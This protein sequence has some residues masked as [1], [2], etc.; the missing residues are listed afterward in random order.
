MAAAG[1]APGAEE[2]NATG[3]AYRVLVIEDDRSQAVFAESILHGAGMETRWVALAADAM[4]ALQDFRPDLVLMDLHLPDASGA[5]L[6][7]RIRAEDA[8]AHLPIVFLTGDPDPETE[9]VAL[10]SGADDF[11]SK[12]IRP[13]HLIS[14]VQG[15]VRRARAVRS[16]QQGTLG[17]DRDP[18]TGL[19]RRDWLLS[20]L[21]GSAAA[22]LVEVQHLDALR[23]RLGFAGIEAL[24]RSAGTLLAGIQPQAARLNDNSFLVLVDAA[25]AAGRADAARAVRDGLGQPIEHAGMP[26]RLRVAVAHAA[27]ADV[28]S[29]PLGAL[30]RTLRRARDDA[31]HLA[32][33]E[34]EAASAADPSRAAAIRAALDD[35]R[36]ELA[37][38]PIAAV[39][40]GGGAQFQTLLR[41]RDEHGLLRTASELI[42]EAEAA[43]L[44]DEVDQWVFDRALS[45]IAARPAGAAERRL[46]VSQS[47]QTI[48]SDPKAARAREALARHGVAPGS[49][50]IDLRMD[51][52]LVH[53]LAMTDFCEQLVPHG[54]AFCLGQYIH[55]D[56]AAG[57]LRQLPLSYLR[58]SPRYSAPDTEAALRGE[59]REIIGIAHGAGIKVIGAQVETP[60]AA[61]SLWMSGVDFIQGN[62]IQGP[63]SSL[64]F[65]FHH[66]VL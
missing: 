54:V 19:Y 10:D 37:F 40:G 32:G 24:L 12:P 4:D 62:L 27:L 31:S 3:E 11:L 47:P 1:Q 46:F 8:Y 36:L 18:K 42:Q 64:D 30:E 13:R 43:G 35:G 21:S 9:F 66:S 5:D 16:A 49:L 55:G 51:D 6:T 56:A 20:R 50:V 7:A 45:V 48:A 23:D 17:E 26:M 15:R 57:L 65:D 41:L 58:L 29:D 22:L 53:C 52:A 44:L 39:A 38:Q 25:D 59:L 14:A 61:A 33:F 60:A 28:A 34:P 63:G 2:G